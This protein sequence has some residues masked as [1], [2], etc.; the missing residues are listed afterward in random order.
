MSDRPTE[1][2]GSPSTKSVRT[3]ARANAWARLIETVVLPTPPFWLETAI[4]ITRRRELLG[5][6]SFGLPHRKSFL[7]DGCVKRISAGLQLSQSPMKNPNF[8]SPAFVSVLCGLAVASLSCRKKEVVKI[9][10]VV[11]VYEV[12]PELL[13]NQ[14]EGVPGAVYA[15]QVDS[16]IHWQPWTK[17]S[18]ERARN[19][20]RLVFCVIAMPQQPESITSTCRS[21]ISASVCFSASMVAKAFWWQ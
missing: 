7:H 11:P 15:S 19:A 12:A 17:E 9:E 2:W 13:S 8:L 21:G 1:P 14:L 18:L 5:E 3:P 4:L 6:S 16:P 20:G 10:S